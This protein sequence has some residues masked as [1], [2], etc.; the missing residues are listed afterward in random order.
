LPYAG[1]WWRAGR[2]HW[3]VPGIA[4]GFPDKH[5]IR[6]LS[7][8]SPNLRPFPNPL[9]GS[10]KVGERLHLQS[11]HSAD[12]RKVSNA[13][14]EVITVNHRKPLLMRK[15]GIPESI[16]QRRQFSFREVRFGKGG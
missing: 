9:Q 1:D 4:F 5:G 15:P 3:H 8:F 7:A 12:E 10:L 14:K 6:L 16:N 2:P 13:A 11:A